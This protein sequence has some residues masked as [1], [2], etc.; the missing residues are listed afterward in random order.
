[1]PTTSRLLVIII[2][3]EY[4]KDWPSRGSVT[5]VQLSSHAG[6]MLRIAGA[7]LAQLLIPVQLALPDRQVRPYQRPAKHLLHRAAKHC[8]QAQLLEPIT[9]SRIAPARRL[10]KAADIRHTGLAPL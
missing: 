1:M 4:R 7:L 9:A 3:L 6:N 8:I 5:A 10:W 2:N